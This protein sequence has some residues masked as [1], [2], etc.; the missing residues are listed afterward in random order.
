MRRVRAI[1]RF[2]VSVTK[3]NLTAAIRALGFALVCSA[4]IYL[5]GELGDEFNPA[6]HFSYFTVLSNVFAALV[7]AI[8]VFRPVPDA[9]RGA[10][11]LYLV[12]T[13][14]VYATLLRGVDVDSP[15]YANAI[16][17]L[18]MP[19]LIVVEWMIGPPRERISLRQA[20]TWL[21]FPIAYLAYTLVR[22][23]IVDWY[24]YPFLDPND[25]G[26]GQV[27]V[28]SVGVAVAVCVLA[29]AVALIGNRKS[30]VEPDVTAV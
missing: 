15:A 2:N 12:V 21:A 16:L 25:G 6:N 22:G 19:I 11:V 14:I 30:S 4:E 29:W 10:A 13:G 28:V 9:V 20:A 1:R 5:I 18:V 23:P 7:L 8:G 27:A 3:A 26:Y 17:H 24:P